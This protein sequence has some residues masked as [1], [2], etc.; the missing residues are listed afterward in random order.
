[1]NERDGDY[2]SYLLRMWRVHTAGQSVWRASLQSTE[3]G[4]HQG[5]ATLDQLFAFLQAETGE[6]TMWQSPPQQAPETSF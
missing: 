5:F 4:E 2:T 1:M 6:R 3:N